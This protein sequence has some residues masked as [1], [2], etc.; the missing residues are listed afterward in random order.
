MAS[1]K[2][3]ASVIISGLQWLAL[4]AFALVLAAMIMFFGAVVDSCNGRG[5]DPL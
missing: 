2:W 5:G 4:C 1:K 3:L